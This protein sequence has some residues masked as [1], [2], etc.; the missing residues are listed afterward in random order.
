MNLHAV[1]ILFASLLLSVTPAHSQQ[2]D[3]SAR[4]NRICWQEGVRLQWSDFRAPRC[5]GCTYSTFVAAA[6]SAN[7]LVVGFTTNDNKQDYRVTCRFLRDSSWVNPVAA[8]HDAS[9]RASTLAH[10]QL[11]FDIYELIA[12]KIRQYA[13]QH[14]AAGD[15]LFGPVAAQDIKC[16]L[17]ELKALNALYDDDVNFR[18]PTVEAAAQRRWTLRVARELRAL[19]PYRSTATTC[20]D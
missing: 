20:P 4:D 11:H 2:P 3:K 12:R 13:A 18:T 10:E 17:S 1:I 6:T 15:D 8:Q 7:V 16:L 9:Y 14:R 5:Y 19:A